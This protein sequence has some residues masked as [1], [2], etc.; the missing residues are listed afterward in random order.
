MLFLVLGCKFN[1]QPG[2]GIER[3]TCKENQVCQANGECTEPPSSKHYYHWR[4]LL[5]LM[6]A[7]LILLYS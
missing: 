1:G 5:L 7:L 3:G 6:L 4:A 2:D